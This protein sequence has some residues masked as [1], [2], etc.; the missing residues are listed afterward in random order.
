[1]KTE[2]FLWVLNESELSRSD[3]SVSLL[4]DRYKRKH[5]GSVALSININTVFR[6]NTFYLLSNALCIY[7]SVSQK[8]PTGDSGGLRWSQ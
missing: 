3:I 4:G 5:D 2:H 1:M 6:A 8:G 7:T